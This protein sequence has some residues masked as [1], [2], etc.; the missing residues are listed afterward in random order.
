[1]SIRLVDAIDSERNKAGDSF[2][3]TL[4]SPVSVGDVI[5]IPAGADISGKVTDAKSAAH[6]SGHSELALELTSI[7]VDGKSYDLQTDQYSRQGTARGKN[8]AEKVG[9]GT[10]LGAIIGGLAG[11]GKGAAIGAGVGAGAGGTAQAVTR[12]QQIHLTSEQVLA[13]HLTSPVTVT[14]PPKSDRNR[15]PLKD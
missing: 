9:A 15:Q 6:F 8:T 14:V 10:V 13:F 4:D 5:A 2:R 12:G 3:A 1:L 7:R 11:G